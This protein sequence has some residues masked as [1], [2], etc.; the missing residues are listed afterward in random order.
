MRDKKSRIYFLVQDTKG[1][2]KASIR[3]IYEMALSL[4]NNGFNAIMLHETP[5]YFGV[6]DWL[7][8]EY[9]TNLEHRP[10]E[11][12][13][14]EISPEDLI[15]V[16]EIYGFVMDQITK[17]PCGK[18]VLSQSYDYIFE[19]LQPGQTWTQ[20]G[21]NKCITTS[22]KQ[23][24]YI[25]TTMRSVSVDVIEPTISDVF[26]KQEFPPKTIIGVHTRDHRDTVNL[27]KSFYVKFPQYRWITFRDLRGL[28][29]TEFT[30]AMKESFA[31]VWIDSISSFG[32]FPLESMKMGI[33]VI[34]LVP[35]ITPEWMN[36]EN[37]IWIN[38]Q[39]MIVDVIADFIQNWL[40]DNIN[41]KLYEEMDVTINKLSTKEKF[42]SEVVELFSKM[43][44]TRADSFEA[45]LSKLEITE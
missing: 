26:E 15:I 42:E 1:N 28:S 2:A 3:Y 27:I 22:E 32:T 13:N 24:E 20:L 45:Q 39:N 33:P 10:I 35:N 16:P 5:E 12:S 30:N 14:L 4:K 23:K 11:G 6:T 25:T 17:L 21:F 36:E 29:Q 34:G 7:G 31:S 8:E 44:D 38:N 41:P 40:E 43:I 37:G 19:T 18:I 9:M